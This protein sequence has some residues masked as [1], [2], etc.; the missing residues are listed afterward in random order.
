M[1]N[2]TT[3]TSTVDNGA[4]QD[5]GITGGQDTS[6]TT[7]SADTTTGFSWKNHLSN[8][9]RNSPLAQKFDDS[10][11][12]LGKAFESHANLEKLLGNE[13]VPIPKGPQDTEGWAR[14]QK[15]MGIPDKAEGYGLADYNTPA[16]MKDHLMP[17]SK[18]AEIAHSLKLTPAQTKELW[19][20]YN[21][22]NISQFNK[23]MGEHKNSLAETINKLKGEWGDAYA[24]NV[25]LGQ[26]VINKFSGDQ[27]TNDW[28]TAT[29]SQDPRGIKFLAKIGDQFAENKVG[30]FQVKRFSLAPEE[31]WNEI[32]K[33]QRDPK[34]PY[35]DRNATD[36]EH[37]EAVAYVNR[38]YAIA[39]NRMGGQA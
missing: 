9:L 5:T 27:E 23:I 38:L 19:K 11:E 13:K 33:I 37:D 4:A 7:T 10:I 15:A 17:K 35:N 39:G 8:D 14:F 34:H 18:F 20:V 26:M 1:D 21:D 31:A 22:E 30:E 3:Q 24:T 28:I 6:T 29:L 25:E 32:Q 16:E 36:R 2:Q 12:G